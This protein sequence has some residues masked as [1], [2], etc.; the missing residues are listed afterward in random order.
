[1]NVTG[2]MVVRG[3]PDALELSL[4]SFKKHMRP[5]WK[6]LVWINHDDTGPSDVDRRC[7]DLAKSFDFVRVY[8]YQ[9]NCV[10]GH[11]G[12]LDA[13]VAVSSMEEG[14]LVTMDSDIVFHRDPWPEVTR[15]AH[16]GYTCVGA[17]LYPGSVDPVP[18]AGMFSGFIFQP[19]IDPCFAAFR[20]QELQRL[21]IHG[22]GSFQ[23]LADICTRK[24]WDVGAKVYESMRMAGMPVVAPDAVAK[25]VGH[26]GGTSWMPD[27][28]KRERLAA[29]QESLEMLRREQG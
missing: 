3:Q 19:R 29:I 15:L 4:R 21:R 16:A 6:V 13:M 18:D 27:D 14:L 17:S 9:R 10:H 5:G 7:L 12:A 24:F 20:N 22:G 8:G 25:A 2:L 1:M 28:Q 11:G 23:C 26:W